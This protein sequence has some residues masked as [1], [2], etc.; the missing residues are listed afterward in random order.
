[1]V[2]E[3]P[4]PQ[5]APRHPYT[6]A[7]MASNFTPDPLHRKIIA[8]LSGEIPSAFNLPKGCAF[9]ARCPHA[10]NRCQNEAPLLTNDNG[11]RFACF[12]PL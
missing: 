4:D 1:V 3:L 11:H 6:A 2:E 8:P 9:A 10:T 7:L 12:H 5:A